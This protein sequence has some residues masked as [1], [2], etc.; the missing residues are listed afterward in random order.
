MSV[1]LVVVVLWVSSSS[2]A[3]QTQTEYPFPA[4]RLL[5][6]NHPY[7]PLIKCVKSSQPFEVA[8]FKVQIQGEKHHAIADGD[9]LVCGRD[10]LVRVRHCGD[11]TR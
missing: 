3:D 7:H 6:Y 11:K 10:G 1:N 2:T 4:V 9:G 5:I 8:H